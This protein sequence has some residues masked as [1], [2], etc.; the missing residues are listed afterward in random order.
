MNKFSY[1]LVIIIAMLMNGCL[2]KPAAQSVQKAYPKWLDDP[3]VEND[4]IAA[5]GC[6][7]AHYN[8]PDAQKKLAVSNAIDEIALQKKMTVKNV[9]L[10]R[11]SRNGSSNNISLQ[12]D[13]SSLHEVEKVSVQTK[14]KAYFTKNNG[15]ICA[16]VVQR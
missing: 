16:W 8:G 14:I 4:H 7:R 3:Y 2:A 11:K 13:T 15:D 5:V 1:I 12:E 9:T 6:A 10:R